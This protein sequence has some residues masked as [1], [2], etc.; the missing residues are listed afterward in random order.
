MLPLLPIRHTFIFSHTV[1]CSKNER[2]DR[3]IRI[4][5]IAPESK[6]DA[7]LAVITLCNQ[8]IEWRKAPGHTVEVGLG[9]RRTGLGCLGAQSAFSGRKRWED[10]QPEAAEALS[11]LAAAQL[12]SPPDHSK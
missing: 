11:E 12:Y 6:G 4:H 3:P 9:E 10:T 8:A 7:R 1:C 2:L 5:T